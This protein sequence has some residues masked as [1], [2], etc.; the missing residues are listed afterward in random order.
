MFF[1]VLFGV[2]IYCV[3]VWVG[4]VIEFVNGDIVFVGDFVSVGYCVFGKGIDISNY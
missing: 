4:G 2:I 3:D 1:L